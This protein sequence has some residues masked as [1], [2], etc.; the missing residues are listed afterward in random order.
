MENKIK[1]L[2]KAFEEA[3]YA[4]NPNSADEQ[5][6][7]EVLYT[8]MRALLKDSVVQFSKEEIEEFIA[9]KFKEFADGTEIFRVQTKMMK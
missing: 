2:E 6:S 5:V 3:T 7:E 9:S 8:S 4:F 1:L